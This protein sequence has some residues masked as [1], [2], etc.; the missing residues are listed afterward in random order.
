MSELELCSPL[1]VGQTRAEH[2][3]AV[4]LSLHRP[5]VDHF[6]TNSAGE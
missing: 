5:T 4:S 2:D 3:A 6:L 1:V